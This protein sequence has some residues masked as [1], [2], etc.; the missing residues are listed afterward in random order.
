MRTILLI[1]LVMLILIPCSDNADRI[2]REKLEK[3]TKGKI[4]SHKILPI[5]RILLS[6]IMLIVGYSL[7][8]NICLL[9]V[10]IQNTIF[11]K[12]FKK[13]VDKQASIRYN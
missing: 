6:I 12:N 8:T 4:P 9:L 1:L 10:V 5:I 2:I 13:R 3:V 7:L 11:L